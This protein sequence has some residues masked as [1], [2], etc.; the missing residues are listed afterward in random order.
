MAC[1]CGSCFGVHKCPGQPFSFPNAETPCP[2][3][4][5]CSICCNFCKPKPTINV[6]IQP[7]TPGGHLSGSYV[8]DL[9]RWQCNS[10]DIWYYF[11]GNRSYTLD[12]QGYQRNI[13]I[14]P[15]ITVRLFEP[16]L[17]AEGISVQG[18]FD[19]A[20]LEDNKDRCCLFPSNCGLGVSSGVG[21]HP[22]GQ[23]YGYPTTPANWYCEGVSFDT[24]VRPNWFNYGGTLRIYS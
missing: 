15:E 19:E 12:C 18:S 7:D 20:S 22:F 17:E 16:F 11:N 14:G 10:N 3:G 23:V 2:P 5:T 13:F 24:T 4:C 6:D 1:C 8:L 21:F 9:I